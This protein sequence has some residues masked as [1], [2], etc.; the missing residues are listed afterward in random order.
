MPQRTALS[1]LGVGINVLPH[2]IAEPTELALLPH[3]DEVA[4]RT[5]ELIYTN[6]LGQEIWREPRGMEAGY[7]APQFRFTA[8]I[9]GDAVIERLRHNSLHTGHVF[10]PF[11][12]EAGRVKARFKI[13]PTCSLTTV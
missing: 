4:I 1:E 9:L 6:R 2:A 5:R 10:I 11:A 12:Q 7:K 8:G 13:Q 3:L